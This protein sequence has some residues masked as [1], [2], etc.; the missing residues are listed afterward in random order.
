MA[1]NRIYPGPVTR[2]NAG[3]RPGRGRRP[4]GGE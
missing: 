4:G 2:R 1:P 3:L